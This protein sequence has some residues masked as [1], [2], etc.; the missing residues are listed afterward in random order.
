M[1]HSVI[2]YFIFRKYAACIWEYMY[3]FNGSRS[4]VIVLII[5]WLSK[6]YKPANKYFDEV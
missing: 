6:I 3:K 4:Y 5:N 2:L 1:L